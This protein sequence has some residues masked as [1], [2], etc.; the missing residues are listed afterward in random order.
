MCMAEENLHALLPADTQFPQQQLETQVGSQSE[1][2]AYKSP[3]QQ[4][5]KSQSFN[6]LNRLISHTIKAEKMQSWST[7]ELSFQ[8]R[9]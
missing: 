8:L 4:S 5:K 9:P 3:G 2:I 1:R 6:L 7:P